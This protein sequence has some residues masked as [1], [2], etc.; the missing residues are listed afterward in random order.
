MPASAAIST[1]ESLAAPHAGA[2]V[3]AGVLA[4]ARPAPVSI[5]LPPPATPPPASLRRLVAPYCWEYRWSLLLCIFLNALPGVAIAIQVAAPNY[6]M[7]YVLNAPGLSVHAKYFRLAALVGGYIFAAVFLRMLAWY[8]SYRIFTNVRENILMDLRS[9]FF[10]HINGLCLRFHGKY[11]SG[12]LFTYVMGS[13]LTEISGF[14]H[15]L[16]MNMP[17]AISTLVIAVA[18]MAGWDW[19]MT[20]ILIV[21]VVLTVVTS[22]SGHN[23]L[24]ELMEDYQAAEGKVIG[25]VADIFRGNR[26]VKMY[27]I[28]EKMSATFEASADVLRRKVFDRDVKTHHVNMRQETVGIFC[29]VLVILVAAGRYMNGHLTQGQL[30][31]FLGAFAV[32]QQPVLLMFQLK[33]NQGKAQ[34]S[35]NRLNDV[36]MTDTSTPEPR[37][38]MPVP[39]K[40]ALVVKDLEFHYSADRPVLRGINLTIPFGQRVALVGPSGSGKST[41]AKMFLRLYDPDHGSVSFDHE[42]LRC[43]RTVDV[44]QR[45]GVVP[46]DPYFFSTSIRENLHIVCPSATEERMRECCE[47]ASIWGFV[48]SL[49]E[50]LDTVIG[51]S[52]AR[53][54]GGQRQRLAIARALLHNPDYFVFDEAT[55]ALDTVS[56]RMVQEAFARILPGRT[57]VFIAHRLSTVND[58]D[59]IIVLDEGRI[60]QDGTFEQLRNEPGLFQRMVES[61][62][63]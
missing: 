29:F 18:L 23:R 25:R 37:R 36:L 17:N 5:N 2:S 19:G 43:C 21:S 48:E 8:G 6:L 52:G 53:L 60:I 24:R 33:V 56:E 59:R 27:A 11:S 34:A 35:L 9:R 1:V 20:L 15:M 26:D 54:S 10:R 16:A 12:E 47:M 40:A 7:Q 30:F 42:D 22:T 46:Q 4:G 14:F 38:A 31:S 58:C 49:P 45:F 3:A 61:D 32:L 55:S 62:D 39:E 51:E 57:A 44:R 28:E 41:L 50:G 63:F 13:P